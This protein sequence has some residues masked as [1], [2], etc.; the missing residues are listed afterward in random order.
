MGLGN[1]KIVW[2]MNRPGDDSF[3]T[4]KIGPQRGQK[5]VARG[6]D[7]GMMPL[8]SPLEHDSLFYPSLDQPNPHVPL[9][10]FLHQIHESGG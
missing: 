8:S 4:S 1:K 3:H 5:K 10:Y 6:E 2:L 9:L 7:S